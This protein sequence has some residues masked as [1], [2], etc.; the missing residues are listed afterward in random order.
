MVSK[1]TTV[2]VIARLKKKK[3][4]S[5]LEKIYKPW[6]LPNIMDWSYQY[7]A[8]FRFFYAYRESKGLKN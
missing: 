5:H 7:L 2:I 8:S 1:E 6:L 3:N 4:L